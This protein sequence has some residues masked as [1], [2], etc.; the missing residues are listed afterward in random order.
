MPLDLHFRSFMWTLFYLG[1]F[2]LL[3]DDGAVPHLSEESCYFKYHI[4]F[5]VFFKLRQG[6]FLENIQLWKS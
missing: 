3:C 4:F 1:V 6:L 2:L 5:E